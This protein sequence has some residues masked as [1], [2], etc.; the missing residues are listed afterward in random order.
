MANRFTQSRIVRTSH[1]RPL[2]TAV[3]P[4][5]TSPRPS[6]RAASRTSATTRATASGDSHAGAPSASP[7]HRAGGEPPFHH[8]YQTSDPPAIVAE[9]PRPSPVTPR[10]ISF[11]DS[12]AETSSAYQRR[13]QSLTENNNDVSGSRSPHYRS[14]NFAAA[15]ARTYHSS[16]LVPKSANVPTEVAPTRTTASR[17]PNPR[18]R[19]LRHP[20]P[21]T[22]WTT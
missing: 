12:F 6:S 22:S 21:G 16:P 20:R 17:E 14:S 4:H 2:S 3:P 5:D 7:Y 13:R 19:R 15:Q 18:L 10:Q 1:R 9:P 8:H 11:K